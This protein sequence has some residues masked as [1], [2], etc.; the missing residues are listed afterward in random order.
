MT[1]V[2]ACASPQE[3]LR[4]IATDPILMAAVVTGLALAAFLVVAHACC[5][6]ADAA[7]PH[8]LAPLCSSVG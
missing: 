2:A 6:G 8:V 7:L 3:S 1:S 4:S 5:F